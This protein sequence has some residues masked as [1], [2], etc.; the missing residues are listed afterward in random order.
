MLY[1]GWSLVFSE[2]DFTVPP[3]NT[4]TERISGGLELIGTD[5]SRVGTELPILSIRDANRRPFMR[6]ICLDNLGTSALYGPGT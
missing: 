6:T 2:D 4:E 3:H 1:M 5:W